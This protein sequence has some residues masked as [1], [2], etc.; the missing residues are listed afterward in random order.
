M[1]K[2]RF[3]GPGPGRPKGSRNKTT[4]LRERLEEMGWDLLEEIREDLPKLRPA[5]R[6]KIK[7][8]LM[9]YVYPK[10]ESSEINA[11]VETNAAPKVMIVMP[12]NGREIIDNTNTVAISEAQLKQIE[13]VPVGDAVQ[14]PDE[15][16]EEPK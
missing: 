13:A 15:G 5:D 8:E 16:S 10:L 2:H 12:S 7:A 3:T 9:K 14:M 1:P 4:M 11:N 6:V